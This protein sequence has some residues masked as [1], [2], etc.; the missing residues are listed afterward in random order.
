MDRNQKVVSAVAKLVESD[1]KKK[2]NYFGYSAWTHHIKIVADLSLKLAKKIKAD[3][4]IVELAALLHD[5][6]GIKNAKKFY[7]EH[8]IHSARLAEN[9]LKKLN[10]PQNRIERIKHC[11]LTHRASLAS[12]RE[13]KEA[14]CLASADAMSH[15]TELA[16]L[17]FL[18]YGIR[19]M[20]T[21]E[22][23]KFVLGKIERSWK[24]LMPEAKAIVRKD[25]I[26]ARQILKSS[27]KNN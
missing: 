26:T 22:G 16:D 14:K 12:K 7:P 24:K 27:I 20:K 25:Y 10:Y 13:T 2:S 5:Y 18:A 8:H 17:M 23:A 4:E 6:S 21:E 9:I 15:V 3:Q 1:C 11:I 19:K